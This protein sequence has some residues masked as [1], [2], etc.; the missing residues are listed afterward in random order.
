MDSQQGHFERLNSYVCSL[1][2]LFHESSEW[3]RFKY[4]SIRWFEPF[5][6]AGNLT[7][8]TYNSVSLSRGSC[9]KGP[10][11]SVHRLVAGSFAFLSIYMHQGLRRV[12]FKVGVLE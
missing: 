7:T 12:I 6:L 4:S 2:S 10:S 11:Y 8:I 9:V 1:A 5:W 3:P